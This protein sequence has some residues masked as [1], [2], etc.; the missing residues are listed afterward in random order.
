MK[1]GIRLTDSSIIVY[2]ECMPNTN[3]GTEVIGIDIGIN[4]CL[5]LSNGVQ[6][7]QC[8]QGHTLASIN[9]SLSKKIKGSKGFKRKQRH[10]T[11]FINWSVNQLKLYNPKK[12]VVEKLHNMRR[13][14]NS[15]RF[16]SH[17]TYTDIMRKLELHWKIMIGMLCGL[18]FGFI[19]LQIAWG[20]G[21]VDDWIKPFGTIF[22]SLLKLIAIP[23]ILAS[24]IKGISDLKDISK[25]ANNHI[26]LNK[27]CNN[28]NLLSKKIQCSTKTVHF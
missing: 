15:G 10:R 23:L 14:K 2:F 1:S 24:L 22:V 25:F 20:P 5:S 7:K 3:Y 6:I 17:F 8:P 26:R 18:V 13:G 16:L 19:M 4:S 21:F 12:I 28:S 27:S 9:K 11:N